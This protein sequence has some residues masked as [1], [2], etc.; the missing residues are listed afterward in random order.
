VVQQV[1]SPSCATLRR[2]GPPGP[3]LKEAK[4]EDATDAV[5]GGLKTVAD[6]AIKSEPLKTTVWLSQ[7]SMR[8]RST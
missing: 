5:M 1:G 6:E 2:D 4:K 3:P 7:S 8:C